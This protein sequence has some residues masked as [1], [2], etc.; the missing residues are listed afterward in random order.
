MT[1]NGYDLRCNKPYP[2]YQR[3]SKIDAMNATQKPAHH[4]KTKIKLEDRTDG[5]V[6]DY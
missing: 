3:Q 1:V 4:S 6:T 2:N 5:S